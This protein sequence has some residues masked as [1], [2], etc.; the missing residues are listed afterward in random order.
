MSR[1]KPFGSS[2]SEVSDAPLM[3]VP[4]RAGCE[5]AVKILR[6]VTSRLSGEANGIER[7]A[8][9]QLSHCRAIRPIVPPY[10]TNSATDSIVACVGG[11]LHAQSV[12]LCFAGPGRATS[13][14]RGRQ[15]CWTTG[16]TLR[17]RWEDSVRP[18]PNARPPAGE[19][20]LGQFESGRSATISLDFQTWSVT[21]AAIA[22]V[23]WIPPFAFVSVWW[24]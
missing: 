5:V 4:Q 17:L 22:G 21:F 19:P 8:G 9:M 2:D 10:S 16:R 11:R 24:T 7:V 18:A 14:N 3:S 12:S 6:G 15:R 20:A 23:V 1:L 13:P